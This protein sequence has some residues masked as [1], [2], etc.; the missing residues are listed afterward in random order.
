MN[1]LFSITDLIYV[2]VGLVL[3]VVIVTEVSDWLRRRQLMKL[4]REKPELL[5]KE[6][7]LKVKGKEYKIAK[8]VKVVVIDGEHQFEDE[9][10]LE[11][12][13]NIVCKKIR[14]GF[15]VPSDYRPKVSF[16]K[17]KVYL[18]FYFDRKGNALSINEDKT[19]PVCVDPVIKKSVVDSVLLERIFRSLRYDLGALLTGVG[20]GA[21]ILSVIIFVLLPILGI[22]VLIGKQPIDVIHVYETQPHVIPPGNF[23]VG[24]G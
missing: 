2:A 6:L 19:T 7:T 24:G 5:E 14:M 22:P 11:P 17:K 9:C 4:L 10:R 20:L 23:T 8:K 21:F 1:E 3:F 18:T 16:W 13:N 12:N 15:I